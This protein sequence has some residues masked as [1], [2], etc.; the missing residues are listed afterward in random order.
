MSS[1]V[2]DRLAVCVSSNR[3]TSES[4]RMEASRTIASLQH[5]CSWLPSALYLTAPQVLALSDN[6]CA[7]L[8][9]QV[10]ETLSSLS[11]YITDGL[12]SSAHQSLQKTVTLVAAMLCL[13]VGVMWPH[14]ISQ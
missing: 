13:A 12:L 5:N 7:T 4:A 14:Y 9:I 8:V 10:L 1:N 2:T 6:N 3:A 11:L